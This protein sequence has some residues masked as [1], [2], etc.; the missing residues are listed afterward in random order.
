MP[1][2]ASDIQKL[3]NARNH[4]IELVLNKVPLIPVATARINQSSFTYPIN[5][6]AV[7][8]TSVAWVTA[9]KRG[10]AFS[11]GTTEGGNDVTWGTVKQAP[12]SGV[13]YFDVKSRGEPGYALD[14]HSQLEDDLYITVYAHKPP[15]SLYSAIRNKLFYKEW[16]IAFTDQT[17][18]P[19]PIV[20][21]G[22]HQQVS[23]TD[24]TVQL[25]FPDVPVSPYAWGSATITDYAW[26]CATATPVGAEDETSVTYEFEPGFHIVDLEVTDSNDKVSVGHR[27]VWVNHPALYPPVTMPP[28]V[29]APT[30]QAGLRMQFTLYGDFTEGDIYPG[31]A[32]M[33]TERAYF[34]GD[35][36]D[37]PEQRV[38]QFFGYLPEMS[39]SR[40]ISTPSIDLT[41]ESP[42]N[43]A[44]RMGA[45]SQVMIEKTSPA[46]WTQVTS[47]LSNVIGAFW[48]ILQLH[49]AN[50]LSA[51]DFIFDPD[52][53]LLRKQSFDFPRGSIGAQLDFIKELIP[54]N[55]GCRADGTLVI[56][57]FPQYQSLDDR[58]DLDV[59]FTW[60][61]R[62]I[63]PDFSYASAFANEAAFVQAK[64]FLY[65][66]GATATG[67][68]GQAPGLMPGQGNAVD[69]MTVIVPSNAG[70]ARVLALAG[71]LYAERSAKHKQL[72]ITIRRNMDIIEPA[73]CYVW[74]RVNVPTTYDPMGEGWINKRLIPTRVNRS[75]R[76]GEKGLSKSLSADFQPET[77]G[78][79]GVDVT[80]P[81]GGA[82][83]SVNNGFIIEEPAVFDENIRAAFALAWN[84]V[85]FGRTH[86]F[87]GSFP[88]WNAIPDIEGTPCD[89][90]PDY[91]SP[92]FGEGIGEIYGW[93]LVTDDDELKIYYGQVRAGAATVEL[94]HT[95]TMADETVTNNARIR[96]SKIA[97]GS[98]ICAFKDGTG[99]RVGR[100][101][102]G[103]G[104]WDSLLRVGS[105]ITDDPAN[106]N[107][108][109][110]LAVDYADQQIVSAPDA[111]G[112]YHLYMATA[113]DGSFTQISGSVPS[114]APH[115][116]IEVNGHGDIFATVVTNPSSLDYL[117]TFDGEN[118]LDYEIG[119]G[120]SETG[121][122]AFWS[123]STGSITAIS[124]L[125]CVPLAGSELLTAG[126]VFSFDWKIKW[127]GTPSTTNCF[128]IRRFYLGTSGCDS[129]TSHHQPSPNFSLTANPSMNDVWQSLEF[130]IPSDITR[131][132]IAVLLTLNRPDG[133]DSYE[134]S[135]D[136]ISLDIP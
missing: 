114:A 81:R 135:I 126:T 48:Y 6:V 110:G 47:V 13:F 65:G 43:Y 134:V 113:F 124:F 62:D 20:N 57:A 117:V 8:N 11:I 123:G 125:V 90:T 87:N 24:A 88:N 1:I 19:V 15:W 83:S 91:S 23:I 54:G 129:I 33:L 107:A 131:D 10:Q 52:L 22:H 16:D 59:K 39:A 32:W 18:E 75:Y 14:I 118:W 37:E 56:A 55:I 58:N 40:S 41:V 68:V 17:I 2:S 79:P 69:E 9:V 82:S 61:E 99:T 92:Y 5:A 30:D 25:T 44:R 98:V 7:D 80:P 4:R 94:Q 34:D 53:L 64:A 84:G 133:V 105:A 109:L 122:I 49:T 3:R 86:G 89:W 78:Q 76:M 28:E 136:N 130:T 21:M 26:S 67:Y 50:I 27:Y 96:S 35:D 73:D 85:D 128:V 102:D 71:H 63:I 74:H 31:Q 45:V 127:T 103:G 12:S 121:G 111:G 101:M 46:N 132:T 36:L 108:P 38:S 70:L 115:P 72:P 119:S 112:E 77:F 106:D 51:H 120:G 66:G 100:T 42:L 104:T 29:Q 97:P 116:L 95:Y 60:N 93:L